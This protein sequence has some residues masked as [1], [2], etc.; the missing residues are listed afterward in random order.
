MSKPPDPKKLRPRPLPSLILL[1]ILICPGPLAPASAQSFV[2]LHDFTLRDDFAANP[3]G[4]GPVGRITAD[5]QTGMLYGTASWGGPAAAGTVFAVRKDGSNPTRLHGF[6][7]R[8]DG[9][10][11]AGGV[12]LADNRLFG[13]TRGG[14]PGG[15]GTVFSLGTDGTGF[16]LLHAFSAT[17]GFG[18]FAPNTDGA[19]P[20]ST[21]VHGGGRLFGTTEYGGPAGN[22]TVFTINTDGTGF[23]R[24]HSFV[25]G[26]AE[27]A[28]GN[29]TNVGGIRPRAGLVLSGDSL[30]GTTVGGGRFARGTVFRIGPDGSSFTTL[31]NFSRPT[32]HPVQNPGTTNSDGANPIGGL[33]ILGNS[34]YGTT[35]NG[36][37]HGQGAVFR[38]NTDGT[39]FATLHSFLYNRDGYF[40]EAQLAGSGEHLYGTATGGGRH[41]SGTAFRLRTD[42]SGFEVIH[43]FRLDSDGNNPGPVTLLG[44]SVYGTAREQGNLQNGT[45]FRLS[46]TPRLTIEHSAGSLR[47]GWPAQA[48]GLDFQGQILES[49]ADPDPSATWTP[50]MPPPTPING[51]YNVT[52]PASHPHRFTRLRSP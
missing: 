49:S 17:A 22:G 28:A 36:G 12:I 43:H 4:S 47:I 30:Y 2:V 26:G 29:Y 44:D 20:Q 38:I 34:L 32:F 11:P 42:G 52:H 31:H 16:R 37:W 25:A 45:L 5:P 6:T 51:R 41:G 33:A 13:T 10:Q 39:G 15:S 19:R 24:L 18:E 21:L 7:G 50:D 1:G 3:E 40:L 23:T 46:F 48:E 14:G 35:Q 27:S 9:S 8:T